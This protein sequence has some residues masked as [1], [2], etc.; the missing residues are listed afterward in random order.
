MRKNHNKNNGAWAA[1]FSLTKELYLLGKAVRVLGSWTAK[2]DRD[3]SEIKKSVKRTEKKKPLLLLAIPKP[4]DGELYRNWTL[5]NYAKKV[6]EEHA[7]MFEAYVK[8]R[9]TGEEADRHEFLRECTDSIV[10]ITSFM[11]KA[12]ADIHERQKVLC[13]VNNSNATRDNGKRF[14]KGA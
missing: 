11:N 1:V 12:G 3:I 13:E 14:K 9:A 8:W 10:A 4:C 2:I 5:D 6:D 7:E